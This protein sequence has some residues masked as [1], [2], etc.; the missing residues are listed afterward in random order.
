MST[1]IFQ[2]RARATTREETRIR[3]SINWL[4][5]RWS[6]LKLSS[7]DLTFG[8]WTIPYSEV[9]DAKL[10]TLPVFGGLGYRLIV[11]WHGQAYQFV[12][13]TLSF[14]PGRPPQTSFWEGPLP[15][16]VHREVKSLERG[17]TLVFAVA[18]IVLSLILFMLYMTII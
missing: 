12:L 14:L 2:C 5:S 9:E 10:V 18:I 4:F 1:L 16:P 15:F 7:T 8:N 17:S 13:P 6:I 11:R 3:M